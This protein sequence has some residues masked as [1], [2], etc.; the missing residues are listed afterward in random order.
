MKTNS[1][2]SNGV[3]VTP[4]SKHTKFQGFQRSKSEA[5]FNLDWD[6]IDEKY[7]KLGNKGY[8][9]SELEDHVKRLSLNG[10]NGNATLPLYLDLESG[11]KD[12]TEKTFAGRRN[13]LDPSSLQEKQIL[14]RKGSVRGFKNRVRAGIN[15][16]LRDNPDSTVRIYS[17]YSE[18]LKL[19]GRKWA[20]NKPRSPYKKWALKKPRGPYNICIPYP[21]SRII[22]YY[23]VV[24]S[25]NPLN[26]IKVC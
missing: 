9:Q 21:F 19:L 15:T 5:C 4:I 17:F 11:D 22:S 13:V 25:L 24:K 16:F 6:K 23:F 1:V 2:D 14:S 3:C 7:T 10:V 20:Q 8:T 12:S 18:R 26:Y